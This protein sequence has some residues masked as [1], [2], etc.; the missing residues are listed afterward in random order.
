MRSIVAYIFTGVALL[1]F[2]AC[3]PQPEAAGVLEQA[4]SL[5]ET[6]PDSAMQLIDSFFI[7]KKASAANIIC[8]F[9]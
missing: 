8:V 1:L 3:N 5:M 2:M 6:Y 9:W 4:E 7:P